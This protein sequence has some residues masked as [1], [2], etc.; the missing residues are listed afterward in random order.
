MTAAEIHGLLYG[1]DSAFVIKTLLEEILGRKIYFDGYMDSQ[2]LLNVVSNYSSTLEKLLQID[3]NSIRQS[4]DN[5][6]LRKLGW[7]PRTSTYSDGLN[8]MMI[9]KSHPLWTLL[10][11]NTLKVSEKGWAKATTLKRKIPNVHLP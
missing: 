1:F 10:N 3:V 4:Q 2:T 8:K 5:V 6:E 11:S 7:I 9:K